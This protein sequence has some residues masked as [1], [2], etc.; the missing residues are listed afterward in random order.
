MEDPE[1][2]S[3][4]RSPAEVTAGR[5]AD[6]TRLAGRAMGIGLAMMIAMSEASCAP[7]EWQREGTAPVETQNDLEGC[8]AQADAAF[9]GGGQPFQQDPSFGIVPGANGGR[10]NSALVVPL[11]PGPSGPSAGAMQQR[12]RLVDRCMRELGYSQAA[13]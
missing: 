1:A 5:G 6:L 4:G 9:P 11:S 10:G 7:R 3:E 12:N 13:G 2:L 8:W